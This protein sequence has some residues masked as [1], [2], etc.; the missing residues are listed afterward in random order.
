MK[1]ACGENIT[2]PKAKW[3]V[4]ENIPK[5]VKMKFK[6][7]F[8][9][10]L[11]LV[12]SFGM[13]DALVPVRCPISDFHWKRQRLE[14]STL[15]VAYTSREKRLNKSTCQICVNNICVCEFISGF[16]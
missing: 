1:T 12:W 6:T 4:N 14:N 10:L 2:K 15:A 8:R 16:E 7:M 9:C 11:N 3:D 5:N 13:V